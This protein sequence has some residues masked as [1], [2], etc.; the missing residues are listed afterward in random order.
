MYYNAL[1]VPD[2]THAYY[3]ESKA[4][5]LTFFKKKM[6]QGRICYFDLMPD[7][8]LHKSDGVV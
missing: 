8:F 1:W 4:T 3:F 7:R 6:F 5:E 2:A